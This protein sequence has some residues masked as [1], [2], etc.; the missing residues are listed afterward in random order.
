MEPRR[1]AKRLRAQALSRLKRAS[2]AAGILPTVAIAAIWALVL[3]DAASL[4]EESL[5]TISF[6]GAPFLLLAG[7]HSR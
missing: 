1:E 2:G 6:A 4:S 7:L 5:R 3:A